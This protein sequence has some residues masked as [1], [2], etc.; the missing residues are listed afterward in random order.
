MLLDLSMHKEFPLND[1]EY[2]F[3]INL[4]FDSPG[5]AWHKEQTADLNDEFKNYT[6]PRA[7]LKLQQILHVF[8]QHQINPK[9]AVILDP[10]LQNSSYGHELTRILSENYTLISVSKEK[11]YQELGAAPC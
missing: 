1:R 7:C 8:Y 6:L 2:L 3:I 9:Y 10:R 11:L 5:N 4:P